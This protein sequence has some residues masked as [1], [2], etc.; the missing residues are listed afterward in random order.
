MCEPLI[1]L[2]NSCYELQIESSGVDADEYTTHEHMSTNR[3][4][5]KQIEKK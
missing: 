2:H 4:F 5:I 3:I 1:A